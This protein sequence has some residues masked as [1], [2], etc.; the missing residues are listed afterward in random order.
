[1]RTSRYQVFCAVV[2][3]GSFTQAARELGYTQSAVSQT[4]HSLES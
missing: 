3:T 4:V 2:E 1:M